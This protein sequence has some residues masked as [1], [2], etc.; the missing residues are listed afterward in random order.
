MAVHR[1]DRVLR[2]FC[3]IPRTL[4]GR[5]AAVALQRGLLLRRRAPRRRWRCH[6]CPAD[7]GLYHSCSSRRPCNRPRVVQAMRLL[8]MAIAWQWRW[9]E[10]TLIHCVHPVRALPP[11][12]CNA[13]QFCPEGTAEADL[14]PAGYYC[15]NPDERHEC[16]AVSQFCPEGSIVPTPVLDGLCV[17]G[18]CAGGSQSMQTVLASCQTLAG[19]RPI[20]G[21]DDAGVST[22]R[23]VAQRECEEGIFCTQGRQTACSDPSTFCGM[24]TS[25]PMPV[26]NGT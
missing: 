1:P 6:R 22:G 20:E 17:C 5:G 14:C 8:F 18:Y 16:V 12:P 9:C 21:V 26:L 2:S 13:P 10:L 7:H 4:G 11:Q 3:R 24:T 15:S 23:Y 25:S 19:Y